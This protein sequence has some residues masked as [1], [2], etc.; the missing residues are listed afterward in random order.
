MILQIYTID[1]LVVVLVL[2]IHIQIVHQ[3]LMVLRSPKR[4][5]KTVSKHFC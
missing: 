5:L 1:I 2:S 4:A 3:I